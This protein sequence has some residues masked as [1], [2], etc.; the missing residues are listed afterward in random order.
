MARGRPRYSQSSVSRL[1]PLARHCGDRSGLPRRYA[2]RLF[3]EYRASP[4]YWRRDAGI[5]HRHPRRLRRRHAVCRHQALRARQAER[6]GVEF[7]RAQQPSRAPVAGR[8]RC[9]DRVGAARR[10]AVCRTHGPLWAA[11]SSRRYAAID[12][13]HRARAATAHCRHSRRRIPRRGLPRRRRQEPRCPSADQGM[14]P[15]SGRRHRSRP[16]GLVQASRDRVQ[17]AVRRLDQGRLLLR[18]PLTAARCGNVRRKSTLEPGL[19]PAGESYRAKRFDLQ[20]NIS[21]RRRSPLCA[22]QSGDRSDLQSAG[23]GVAE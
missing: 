4:R 18:R 9:P 3:G 11:A 12:G 5:D 19:V 14:R 10:K 13:L 22:N 23:A 21:R 1:Q 2:G 8:S 7:H 16:Y 20:S 6:G 17:C 15:R